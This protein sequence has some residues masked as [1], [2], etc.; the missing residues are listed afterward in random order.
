MADYPNYRE[1]P[2]SFDEDPIAYLKRRSDMLDRM[3]AQQQQAAQQQAAMQQLMQATSQGVQQ[4]K[5]QRPDYDSALEHLM[6]QRWREY[7]GM[8]VPDA[9]KPAAFEQEAAQMAAQS[10]QQ[11]RNPA[12]AVYETAQARGYSGPPVSDEPAD[13]FGDDDIDARWEMMEQE[14][15]INRDSLEAGFQD[16]SDT[17]VDRKIFDESLKGDD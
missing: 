1:H 12:E 14:H 5:K 10:L 3:V 2:E 9:Q 6:D 11:G 17:P 13:I 7:D 16:E 4:F 15:G 8:G